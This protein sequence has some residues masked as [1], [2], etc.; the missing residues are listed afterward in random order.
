MSYPVRFNFIFAL[1]AIAVSAPLCLFG[2]N[3]PVSASFTA[4]ELYIDARRKF[5]EGDYEGAV[6]GFETFRRDFGSSPQAAPALAE[7]RYPLVMSLLSLQKFDQASQLISEALD[8]Q[9][10][11]AAAQREELLFWRGVCLMQSEDNAGAR[12]ALEAFS[13]EFPT[14]TKA[15]EAQ[16]LLG[17]SFLLEGQFA[18]AADHFA[19]I[20][21]R[22]QP[23]DRGRA[24]VLQLYA[25]LEAGDNDAALALVVDEFPRLHEMLQIATFQ[26]L[27]LQLGSN[28]LE[29]G[30][31]RD[32]I[33]CLQR[34][35]SRD[36]LVTHQQTRLKNLE[37][38]LAAAEAQPRSD[39]YRKFHLKQMIAKV[40]RE[41]DNFEKLEEFDAALRLRLATA[42][43]GMRRY[44]EAALILEEMLAKMPPS[45]IVEAASVTLVQAWMETGRWSRVT[46]SAALFEEKFP[47][48]EQLPLVMY[49]AG[50]AQQRDNDQDAAIAT[51]DGIIKKYP[52]S[53]FAARA[54]FMRGF[55][56]LLAEK[57]PEAVV[58]FEEFAKNHPDHELREAATYWRG[59]GFSLNKQHEKSRAAMD[60]YLAT[61]PQGASAGLALF[62]KAYGAHSMMDYP[63]S[64]EEMSDYLAKYPGHET[65]DEALVLLGDALMNEGEIDRGIAAYKRI[66]PSNTRFFEEGWFKI[67]KALRLLED[68]DGMRAHFQ[69]FREEHARSPRVAEAIYW[70]GWTHRQAEEPEKARVVYWEAIDELGND[71]SIRSVEDLF[72]ALARLYRGGEE[73]RQ[74]VTQLR[75]LHERAETNEETTLA[76]RALWAQGQAYARTDPNRARELMV[77]AGALA[78]VPNTNPLILADIALAMQETGRI[79]E[80]E[81]VWRDLVK[82]NPRAAQKDRAFA[83]L[84]EIE[85]QRGRER[86]ALDWIE[87]FENETNGSV[88]AASMFL[89]KGRLL[90]DRGDYP[91]ARAAFEAVLTAPAATGQLKAE[92]LFLTG[93]TFMAENKPE[94]AIPYFQRIYIMHGRWSDWVARAYFRSGEA[95]EQLKDVEAARKTYDEM[96]RVD[97]IQSL[98]EVEKG[99]SRLEALGGPISES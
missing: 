48:S 10:P 63:L 73:Q 3:T 62:R 97:A 14:A 4:D 30:R 59:M 31:M 77:Q 33:L 9:P 99:R 45:P 19:L 8:S 71:P 82:W 65:N 18:E 15:S 74:Y 61:Y 86:A 41:L 2:Q 32:A 76:M 70:I 24:T 75:D 20:K 57:N 67:G 92:S 90:V 40:R 47:K 11:L 58:A 12:N 78:D 51:F 43:L 85:L 54:Y 66:N 93:E 69:Q 72:P 68:T 60:E 44:R 25:L 42:F 81:E 35:W 53:D 98:P 22:L 95:F 21:P 49:L 46:E 6:A 55:S 23:V 91:G 39:A 28:F 7:M 79:N 84:A 38:A 13:S 80:S 52:K 27:A 94:L 89:T 17:T 16:L 26:T 88:L 64:I 96:T 29:A 83:S 36:R 50:T 87:R 1:L 56:M 37:D 5:N 34:V